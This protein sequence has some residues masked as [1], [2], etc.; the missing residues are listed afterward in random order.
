MQSSVQ[1]SRCLFLIRLRPDK[2]DDFT[3]LPWTRVGLAFY[4]LRSEMPV[5]AGRM[6]DGCEGT[7]SE[8]AEVSCPFRAV[9]F[10]SAP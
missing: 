10:W 3:S 5:A 8:S 9:W 4:V 7:N 1:G 6:T 2:A